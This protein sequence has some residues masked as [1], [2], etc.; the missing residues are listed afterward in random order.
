MGRLFTTRA[1]R[2]RYH[3]SRAQDGRILGWV[4]KIHVGT[5]E[6][7]GTQDSRIHDRIHDKIRDRIRDRTPDMT[8]AMT[9]AM[10]HGIL[11]KTHSSTPAST[12]AP[13]HTQTPVLPTNTHLQI[14]DN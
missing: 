7:H 5:E 2:N 9:L 12:G 8:L 13:Q 3:R 14:D 1:L 4:A 11:D 6:I 10:T